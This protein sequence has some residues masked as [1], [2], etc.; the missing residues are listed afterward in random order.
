MCFLGI[1]CTYNNK[2]NL[3]D[4]IVSLFKE[5]RAVPICPE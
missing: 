3:N 4:K 5:G 1:N 2:C